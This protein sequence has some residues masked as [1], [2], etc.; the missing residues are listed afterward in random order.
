MFDQTVIHFRFIAMKKIYRSFRI[1]RRDC[2]RATTT[3]TRYP[4]QPPLEPET[5][6]SAPPMNCDKPKSGD[7]TQTQPAQNP[8]AVSKPPEWEKDEELVRGSHCLFRVKYLGAK[9]IFD[10]RGVDLCDEAFSSLMGRYKQYKRSE[11]GLS[12]VIHSKLFKSTKN[13]GDAS[14]APARNAL[15]YVS[16][17]GLRVVDETRKSLIVDQT[18]EKV[19]FCAPVRVDK[20][21]FAYIARDGATKRWMCHVLLAKNVDVCI[22]FFHFVLFPITPAFLING[23]PLA[24]N[25]TDVKLPTTPPVETTL[26]ESVDVKVYP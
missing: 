8:G 17:D 21:G 13:L 25:V 1:S 9:E 15:F 14:Q 16:S 11:N 6:N 20:R 23:D 22:N 2:P 19:S 3:S 10:S 7:E 5:T 18:I 4:R 24:R 26:F 12:S